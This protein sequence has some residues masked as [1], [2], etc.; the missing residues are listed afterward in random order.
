MAAA[1]SGLES[2]KLG[3]LRL[4]AAMDAL[5]VEGS[6]SGAARRLELSDAATSRLL[7]QIRELL[8]DPIL[9]RS[10]RRMIATPKAEAMRARL[11]RLSQEIDMLIDGDVE[12]PL[13]PA[14]PVAVT[15]P[16][17][18][19]NDQDWR[20]RT[21]SPAERLQ[22]R[23]ISDIENFSGLTEITSP[24]LNG[25]DANDPTLRLAKYIAITGRKIG[26]T[27]PLTTQETEDAFAQIFS[28]EADPM[29]IS[30]LLALIHY[31]GE[32]AAELAGMIVAARKQFAV[33]GR[34]KG[35]AL[36]WPCY[37][38]P[39]SSQAPW[40]MQAA[41][42]VARAGCKV[43]LHGH[44]G[45]GDKSGKLELAAKSLGIP[46]ATSL[47][48][49]LSNLRAH[50]V[51]YL[52]LGG[53][54]PQ[55]QALL[56]LYPL[57]HSRSSINSVVPLLNPLDA[58]ASLLGVS[59]SAYRTLHRDA[60]ILLGQTD[61]SVSANNRDVAELAPHR[62]QTIYRLLRSEACDLVIASQTGG[63]A[64]KRVHL[65]SFEYWQAVWTGA[66]IDERASRTIIGTAALA[67]LTA[68]SAPND[69]YAAC[70]AEAELLWKQR[71]DN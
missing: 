37:L 32:T 68:R 48:D 53:F 56:A 66:A 19:R 5:L 14:S 20:S 45:Q 1:N 27:R 64:E 2:Q 46:L 49:G 34:L 61:L 29:Q 25:D 33:T 28:G 30:A 58:R 69:H 40:F 63:R 10:G 17:T 60:A 7:G 39:N 23:N 18:V 13:L 6:V 41:R 26:Q 55:L 42:L 24:L 71:L 15:A 31:R 21:I 9:V 62:M 65:S 50:S 11:R 36:D 47:R 70:Y 35:L 4:L 22:T 43:V 52:P 59:Q 8:N 44:F 67:L 38:S 3:R 54:A 12:A 51:T 57:F 16:Q